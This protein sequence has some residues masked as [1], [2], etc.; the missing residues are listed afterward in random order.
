LT[1]ILKF[2]ATIVKQGDMRVIIIPKKL[3]PKI[4]KHEGDQVKITI[5]DI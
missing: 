3:H 2:V 5:E 1:E 4:S